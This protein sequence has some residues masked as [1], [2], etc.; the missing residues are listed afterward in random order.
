MQ[1]TSL[2]WLK[3]HNISKEHENDQRKLKQK[4]KGFADKVK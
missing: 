2:G 4:S 3:E 1:K